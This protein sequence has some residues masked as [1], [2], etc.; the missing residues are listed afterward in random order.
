M[1]AD[2]VCVA[3]V[4]DVEVAYSWHASFVDLLSWDIAHHQRVVRGGW[5]AM[6]YGTGG[7]E[8]ARNK[9]VQGFLAD[10]DADWL[11]WI[12]TDM[13]F[14]P[15]IVDRLLEHAD[16]VHRPIVGAL[17]FAWK[18]VTVDGLGGFRC[19]PR[20]T[21]LDAV[22]DQNGHV[23]LMGVRDYPK[24]ALV[25]CAATGSAALLIHRSVFEKIAERYGPH[26]YDRPLDEAGR[27]LGEDTAFCVR[28]N[29]VGCPTHVHTGIGTT[30]LKHLWVSEVEFDAAYPAPPADE[31]CAVL[32]PVLR[33]P[34][35]AAPFMRSLR[36]S[37]GMANV[38]AVANL[39]DTTTIEAW[40][41]AGAKVLIA[42]GVSF[43]CK[44]NA[45]YR[46]TTEP[47]MLLVGDDVAFHPGWL[48]RA[49]QAAQGGACV[50]GTNDLGHPRVMRGEHSTHMLVRRSYVAEV[51]ASWDGPGVVCHEGYRHWF[52]DD[53]IVTAAKQRGVWTFATGSLVEHLHP[54]WSKAVPDEVYALGQASA[55]A[56]RKVFQRRAQTFVG[57][58]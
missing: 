57:A 7:I 14:R 18:E 56:D 15:D 29:A 6:R 51:G 48:D 12:D 31:Q 9:T 5:I 21:I 45:G 36:A 24:N 30:H 37:T 34:Q 1:P 43:A 11:F 38:Y 8:E 50:V 39:D 16:P 58:A 55:E 42:D 25:R 54:A 44:A 52:V 27:K 17:A 2:T 3:Y 20:P 32:V 53:E 28:A 33:R 22:T 46:Q 26:W 41:K 47:W 13:G 35:N 10:K 23:G 40:S 19:Q 49:L 4:H